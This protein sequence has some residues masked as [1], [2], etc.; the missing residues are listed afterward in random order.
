MHPVCKQPQTAMV[1][2]YRVAEMIE[3][4]DKA[5]R[6]PSMFRQ[7][8]Q[9][10]GATSIEFDKVRNPT[11]A[12]VH[13]T[14]DASTWYTANFPQGGDRSTEFTASKAPALVAPAGLSLR[15]VQSALP[16]PFCGKLAV[17]QVDA[18]PVRC[19]TATATP[20]ACSRTL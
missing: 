13:L 3:T 16:V 4:I 2:I 20:P 1:L 11:V 12:A 8:L 18:S 17:Y 9:V 7:P 15:A 6:L 5:D 14:G 19:T 10:A